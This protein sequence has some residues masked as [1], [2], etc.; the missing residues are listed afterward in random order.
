MK[1]GAAWLGAAGVIVMAGTLP[2]WAAG[3][4]A[5]GAVMFNRCSIC[6]SNTRGASSR[7]GPNLFGVVGR[8]AGSYPGYDYSPALKKAGFVWT[9]AK[10]QSWLADP[11]KVVPGN[12]MPIAGIANPQQRAD[13]AAYLATLR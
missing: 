2:A 13:L 1:R 5:A 9:E 11:Q 4:P 10:L 3:N 6:H 12:N 7:M 8:R